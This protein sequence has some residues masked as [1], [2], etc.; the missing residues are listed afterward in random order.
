MP[1]RQQQSWGTKDV[2]RTATVAIALWAAAAISAAQ[3]QTSLDEQA[4]RNLP[5]AFCAAFN[6]HDGH[7]L[8]QIMADDID[9]VTV[10]ATWLHGKSDFEKY[11]TRLLNGRFHSIK[12]EVLQVAV[13]FLR[14]DIAIVHWS[15]TS[16]G[17]KNPDGT[18]RKRR[19]GM[20]TMLAAKR[21][22][23]WLVE[24][25]QNDD[26]FPGLPPEFDGITSPMPMPDQIGPQPSNR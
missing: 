2:K 18:A 17:D 3:A 26:S 14:P 4:V 19:Y 13:R 8:A 21:S 11:H 16:T 22:G 9:F 10:G 20:M 25:S 6:L 12:S 23:K 5:Q 1:L 15:W 7:Q 24:A